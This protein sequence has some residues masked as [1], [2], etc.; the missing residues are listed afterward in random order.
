ME[1]M[2]SKGKHSRTKP[3]NGRPIQRWQPLRVASRNETN[4]PPNDQRHGL[5]S[6][7]ASITRHS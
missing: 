1:A 7:D 6:P 4:F 5:Q 2:D 3:L